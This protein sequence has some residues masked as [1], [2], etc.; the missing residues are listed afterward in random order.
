MEESART[1]DIRSVESRL[2]TPSRGKNLL[3]TLLFS[4][5][6]SHSATLRSEEVFQP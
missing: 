1:G 5:S 6:A 3:S 4:A 2:S